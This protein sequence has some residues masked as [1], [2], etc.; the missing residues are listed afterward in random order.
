MIGK[1]KL[2][3]VENDALIQKTLSRGLSMEPRLRVVATANN[4]YEA[5]D[6]IVKF[7]PDV[8]ILDLDLPG[9]DGLTLI[10]RLMPQY[11]LPVVMMYTLSDSVKIDTLNAMKLGAVDYVVKPTTFTAPTI[12]KMLGELRD[13]SLMVSSVDLGY[14]KRKVGSRGLSVET[15]CFQE[16]TIVIGA[17]LGGP[18][19]LHSLLQSLPAGM[20]PIAI[21]QHMRADYTK[22]FAAR[23]NQ[24]SRLYVK[25]AEEG[26]PLLRGRVLVAPGGKQM[27]IIS[28]NGTQYVKITEEPPV[29]RHCPSVEVLMLSASETLKDQAIGVIMTG[30]GEDGA[31]GLKAMRDA[32]ART[33]GQD[34]ATCVVFGMPQRANDLNAVEEFQPLNKIG[35]RIQELLEK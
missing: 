26:D 19:A 9:V 14:L 16:K 21:V 29:C 35:K 7:K 12:E 27:R 2:L 28:K 6:H 34:E 32:G 8:V 25:E 10:Q 24:A 4:I 3:I 30:M 5:S 22:Q 31:N 18:D 1:V 11:P 17:S 15:H 23:L 33:I 13:K 20:P